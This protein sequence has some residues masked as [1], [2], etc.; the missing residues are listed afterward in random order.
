[1]VCKYYFERLEWCPCSD[2]VIQP[3]IPQTARRDAQLI[4]ETRERLETLS[5]AALRMNEVELLVW[6]ETALPDY[7]RLSFSSRALV[8]RLTSNE[9]LCWW[10]DG[11]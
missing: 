5:S 9:F 10:D 2:R 7:V 6:P 3:N 11:F 4:R 8:N 1:M